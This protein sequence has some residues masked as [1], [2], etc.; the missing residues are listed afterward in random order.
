MQPNACSIALLSGN[1]VFLVQRAYAPFEGLWTLPGGRLEPGETALECIKRELFEETGLIAHTP[2]Q[3][4]IQTVG[5]NDMRYRLA[6]FAAPHPFRAPTVSDE[7]S[8]WDWVH[9]EEIARYRTTEG[10][11][12]IVQACLRHLQNY[13]YAS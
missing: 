8:N 12:D 5:E 3:V 4:L 9:I 2:E 13:G 11:A 10:L 1:A 6:V 7:I